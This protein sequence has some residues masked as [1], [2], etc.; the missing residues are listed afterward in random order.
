MSL[1]ELS[2]TDIR[3]EARRKLLGICGVYKI[4]DGDANRVCQGQERWSQ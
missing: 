1:E 3:E 4:C 2:L